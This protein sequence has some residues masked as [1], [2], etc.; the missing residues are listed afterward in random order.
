MLTGVK[1]VLYIHKNNMKFRGGQAPTAGSLDARGSAGGLLILSAQMEVGTFSFF[2]FLFDQKQGY[3]N[4][5]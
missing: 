5:G 1:N 2:F 4:Y 3:S